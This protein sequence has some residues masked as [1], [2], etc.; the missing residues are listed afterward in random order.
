VDPIVLAAELV[1]AGPICAIGAW[2][3]GSPNSGPGFRI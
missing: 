2:G 1:Q 3:G